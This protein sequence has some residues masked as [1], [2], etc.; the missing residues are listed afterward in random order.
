MGNKRGPMISCIMPSVR[1]P[2]AAIRCF[3][4]QTYGQR[5]MVIVRVEGQ[6]ERDVRLAINDF[7]RRPGFPTRTI[8]VPDGLALGELRN[9]A[10]RESRGSIIAFMDDD[11]WSACT[12]LARIVAALERASICG[13]S[14]VTLKDKEAKRSWQ[15]DGNELPKDE[16][17]KLYGATL[18][19]KRRLWEIHHFSPWLHNGEDVEFMR[20][21]AYAERHDFRDPSMT[22]HFVDGTNT[23]SKIPQPPCWR[24]I[25]WAEEER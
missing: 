3:D 14:L 2:T 1:N 20:S 10:I 6:P 21:T 8:Y 12:R 17:A 22:T 9:I 5:E 24:E 4:A 18:A 23:G 11:D 7:S 19:F 16:P 15:W 13:S 25:P